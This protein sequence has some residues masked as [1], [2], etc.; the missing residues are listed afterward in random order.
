MDEDVGECRTRMGRSEVDVKMKPDT[1]VA[2]IGMMVLAVRKRNDTRKGQAI[3]ARRCYP[4][5]PWR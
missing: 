5:R 1:V 3:E 4:D 2:V